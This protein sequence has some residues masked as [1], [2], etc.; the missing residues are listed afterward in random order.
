[1]TNDSQDLVGRTALVTGATSGIGRAAAVQLARQGA[2]VVVHGRDPGRGK[3]VVDEIIGAGGDARF[4]RADLANPDEAL[5]LANDVG[6]VDILVNNA[7]FSWFGPTADLDVTTLDT[8][9]AANV[10]GPYLL[11]SVIGPKMAARG[12]GV[13]INIAS[14]AGTD[15]LAG[16]AAYGA[17]KAA[18]ALLAK[19]WAA[20]FGPSGVRVNAIAP[21]PVYT[22]GASP[23]LISD[24]GDTTLLGRAA[25]PEEI[26]SV[27][28]FLAS[29][30]ASYITGA[31]IPVDAGRTAI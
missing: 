12:N 9:F 28:G 8:L 29:D 5:R 16:G 17:T 7:G 24:L 15:G 4:A 20:E 2:T 27:I 1:M 21:G 10:Q 14:M 18:V 19:S 3:A 22:N 26:G 25:Q 23:E 6:E 13:I 11:V 31:V 30:R